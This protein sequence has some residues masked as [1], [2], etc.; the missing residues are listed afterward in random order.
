MGEARICC[1]LIASGK[2][3]WAI[4]IGG[5]GRIEGREKPILRVCEVEVVSA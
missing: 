1:G 2:E 5:R 4:W 3:E